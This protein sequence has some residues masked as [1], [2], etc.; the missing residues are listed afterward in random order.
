MPGRR[1]LTMLSI[2]LLVVLMLASYKAFWVYQQLQI[3]HAPKPPVSVA[4]SNAFE[5]RWQ[6]QLPAAGTFKA[7][8]GINLSI[9]VPGVVTQLHF[10]SGQRVD[11]PT[12]VA[13]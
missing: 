8:Q 7:L 10:E 6:R 3:L 2:V 9:E 1:M 13:T 11:G 5:K 4:L 12:V